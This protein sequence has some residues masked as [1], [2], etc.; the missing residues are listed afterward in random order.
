MGSINYV[1]MQNP[2]C[3]S[4]R[5][6]EGGSCAEFAFCILGPCHEVKK[7]TTVNVLCG[8]LFC[9]NNNIVIIIIIR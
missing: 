6:G 5:K 2:L 1:P 8:N 9:W 7:R 3:K 4:E